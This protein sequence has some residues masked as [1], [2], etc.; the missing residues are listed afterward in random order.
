MKNLSIIIKL[1]ENGLIFKKFF[2]K[3]NFI[4]LPYM[5]Y[6]ATKP[7][8]VKIIGV[9]YLYFINEIIN[10]GDFLI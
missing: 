5:G 1:N 4:N 10:L 3:K 8:K 6:A 7:D 2:K 9:K